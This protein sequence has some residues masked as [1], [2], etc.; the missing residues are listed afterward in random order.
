VAERYVYAD[1]DDVYA[2]AAE[3]IAASAARALAE[4]G[5]FVVVLAGGATPRGVY[6]RLARRSWDELDW[7][8]I[9]LFWG[10]ERCV[11]PRHPESN[12]GMAAG[13]LL[14]HVSLP[15]G[16]LHRI[17]GEES[18][19]QAASRYDAELAAFF[20]ASTPVALG[21]CPAFDLVLLGLGADGHTASL[22]PG[23]PALNARSWATAARA[24]DG[25][26]VAERVTLTLPAINTARECVFLATG[27]VK[28]ETVRRVLGNGTADIERANLPA[29]RVRARCATRWFLDAAAASAIS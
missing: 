4:R 27:A 29:A 24:P 26:A 16:N 28:A 11:P 15:P 7:E 12:Y 3:H 21:T 5:R 14:E 2:A 18:A 1:V 22:F 8:A 9:H 25:A 23:S 19:E 17:R 20:G 6:R 10:D 13:S